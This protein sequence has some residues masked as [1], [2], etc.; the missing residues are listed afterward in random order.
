MITFKLVTVWET[1]RSSLWFLPT[2]LVTI[3]I[4]LAIGLVELDSHLRLDERQRWWSRSLGVGADGSRDV[5][6]VIAS[7]MINVAGVA[8]S[9]TIVAL[10][11]ASSQ[12][13]SRVLR[14]F[15]R[16]RASQAVLGV[17]VG[18]YVYCLMVLRVIQS[19]EDAPFVPV[20]AVA[21]SVLLALL[22]IVC[23]IYFIHH[24][25][26]S[27]QAE[28][29][30]K[31][32]ADETT[33]AIDRLFP[34]ELG[35]SPPETHTQI[36]NPTV[37]VQHWCPIPARSTGYIQAVDSDSL[38]KLSKKYQTVIRM[39]RSIGDFVTEGTPLVSLSEGSAEPE[40]VS[41]D[42]RSAYTI[43]RQRTTVQDAGFGIRQIVDVALKAL[44]P[45]INDSTTAVTSVHY[46]TAL[47]AR[48]APRHVESP[49][50]MEGGVLRVIARGPTFSSLLGVAFN[51]IRQNAEGNVAVLLSILRGIET[52]QGHTR[53][54][55]RRAALARQAE[56]VARL[57]RRSIP[58][59]EDRHEIEELLQ[60]LGFSEP[61]SGS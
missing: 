31:A 8:F 13:T 51:Q 54:M 53:S 33:D 23:F 5:L 20:L 14:N 56:L 12:Y 37:D 4:G 38:M 50:R 39:E 15:M 34:A 29:I 10:A 24:I 28:S 49:Y 16:D 7:S 45:G 36:G 58:E 18:I 17:F 1:L 43:G 3:S 32:V 21:F 55:Q 60:R 61:A 26:L 2:V 59:A 35:G 44:S 42:L 52:I 25:A 6:S 47:M 30:L 46:L 57:A 41:E 11:L 27:I 9:I 48:L 22:G 19:G 40:E